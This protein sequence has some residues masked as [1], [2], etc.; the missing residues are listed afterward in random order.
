M[1]HL[2]ATLRGPVVLIPQGT[3]PSVPSRRRRR[4]GPHRKRCFT[5]NTLRVI[6]I[7]LMV[8]RIP[9]PISPIVRVVT[10]GVVLDLRG[11]MPRRPTRARHLGELEHIDPG[12]TSP[13]PPLL[14]TVPP[15]RGQGSLDLLGGR[16][17]AWR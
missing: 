5:G 12:T 14:Q 4:Q 10:I 13:T 3:S 2:G 9:R 17:G 7:G 15:H 8:I 1:T 16:R 6:L 11:V